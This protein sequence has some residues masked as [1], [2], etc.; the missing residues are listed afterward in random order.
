MVQQATRMIQCALRNCTQEFSTNGYKKFCSNSHRV[1]GFWVAKIDK[2]L[3]EERKTLL[4]YL[5]EHSKKDAID[6]LRKSI[7]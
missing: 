2:A 1:A 5:R 4:K 3:M 7:K 6:L